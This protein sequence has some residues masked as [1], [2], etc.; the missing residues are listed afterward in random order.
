MLSVPET[1]NLKRRFSCKRKGC[2]SKLW[3]KISQSSLSKSS[4]NSIEISI[5][6]S[7]SSFLNHGDVYK[8]NNL[9]PIYKVENTE[10][11][12]KPNT[13][14]TFYFLQIQQNLTLVTTTNN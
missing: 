12:N 4:T 8:K 1:K 13:I 11:F 7:S 6:K 3:T 14:R 2:I 5:R 9:R 10:H